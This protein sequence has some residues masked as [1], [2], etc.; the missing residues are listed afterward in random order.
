MDN[1]SAFL[2]PTLGAGGTVGRARPG[3]FNKPTAI[4]GEGNPRYPEYV[5]PTD[6]KYAT[7]ARGLWQAAGAHFMEDGG[8]L[9][10]IKGA[11]GS[12]V[13]T[14]AS[15]GKAALDFL[16]DPVDKAKDLLMRPLKG[17][18]AAIGSSSWA[19]M[20]ARLPRMAVDGLI[21]AVKSVG[22]DL[23]GFGGGGG[24]GN[25]D[26]GGSGVKRWTGVVRQALGLVG[27]PAAYTGITLRRMNQESGGNPT[28]VNKWD[29]NWKAGYPSVGL[30]QVIRPTFQSHAGRFRKTGPFSYGVSV[31]PLANVYA[32]MRYAL[33]AY[34]SLPRAYNRAGGYALGTDGASSGWHWTGELGPELMKLPAGTKIRS[35]RA[36]VRQAAVGAPAV[37]H[38]TVENHGVIGSRQEVLDWLVDSLSQLERRNRLPRGLGGAA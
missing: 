38:L 37:V 11:I 7:R 20:A 26:I 21:D 29:S 27:Q 1:F 16:S 8:I 6:P 17:I 24:G 4:V 14:G 36:S 12:A 22:S 35:H 3:V 32:S 13:S 19:R 5:I 25:V 10:S 23:L 15:V 30:M 18:A 31:N 28:I 9:G 33:A 2:T 34:G